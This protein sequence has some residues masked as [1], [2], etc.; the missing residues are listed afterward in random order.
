MT[1]IPSLEVA[2]EE[3]AHLAEVERI[4]PDG[5]LIETDIES[6]DVLEWLFQF[7]EDLGV[8]I[9]ESQL[10][11][12]ESMTVRDLYAALVA[13]VEAQLARKAEREDLSEADPQPG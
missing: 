12:L 3:L 5:A 9:D 11:G 8:R 7:E 6:V 4:D 1:E 10:Q 2:L 13:Q